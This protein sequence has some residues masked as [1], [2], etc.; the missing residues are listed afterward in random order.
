MW[1]PVIIFCDYGASGPICGAA[2]ELFLRSGLPIA[3]R[4]AV[5]V[6]G[7]RARAVCYGLFFVVTRL[8]LAFW[9]KWAYFSG[10]KPWFWCHMVFI[11]VR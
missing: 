6:W 11:E 4:M 2:Y 7:W 3:L 1:C 5:R 10:L 9:G 8:R